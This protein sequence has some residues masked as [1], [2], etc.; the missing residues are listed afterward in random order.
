M[1]HRVH[2][3]KLGRNIK[4]INVPCSLEGSSV[5][6]FPKFGLFRQKIIRTAWQWSSTANSLCLLDSLWASASNTLM[7]VLK[8]NLKNGRN[9]ILEKKVKIE[10][11]REV[12]LL[13]NFSTSACDMIGLIHWWQGPWV[14]LCTPAL[15]RKNKFL[16]SFCWLFSK[17]F[18][19]FL[20]IFC[21]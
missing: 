11:S 7:G 18:G 6:I 12:S 21:F 14:G 5:Q 16:I 4:V 13:L 8:N 3:P 9:R 1:V 20:S 2:T 10:N 17:S 19:N 15:V